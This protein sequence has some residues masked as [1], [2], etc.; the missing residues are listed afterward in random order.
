MNKK[1]IIENLFQVSEKTYYNHKK[2]GKPIINLI[3]TYFTDDDLIEFLQTNQINRFKNIKEIKIE[4]E[5]LK[6]ITF[7]L[8]D[9]VFIDLVK[10]GRL[11]IE[12]AMHLLLKNNDGIHYNIMKL[13]FF[14][15]LTIIDEFKPRPTIICEKE[16]KQF[17]YEMIISNKTYLDY[18]K[19]FKLLES[20][21]KM[22]CRIINSL[23]NDDLRTEYFHTSGIHKISNLYQIYNNFKELVYTDKD[24]P[25]DKELLT[26]I[27][28]IYNSKPLNL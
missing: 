16:I 15:L 18:D 24:I 3:E 14:I 5:K 22:L 25:S 23:R 4:N 2:L 8:F 7:S 19:L 21:S 10:L 17:I 28:K 6:Q 27:N 1:E 13:P 11:K 12:Q 20:N 9:S 26:Q